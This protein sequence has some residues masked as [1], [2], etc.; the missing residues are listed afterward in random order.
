MGTRSPIAG[1]VMNNKDMSAASMALLNWIENQEIGPEEAVPVLVLTISALIK[2]IAS[3]NN[4]NPAEG[5]RIAGE[6]IK[7]TVEEAQ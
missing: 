2:G 4:A 7:E 6:M 3:R 1:E 5:A